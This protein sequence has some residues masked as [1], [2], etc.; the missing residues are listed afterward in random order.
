MHTNSF[1]N[2]NLLEADLVEESTKAALVGGVA[3]VGSQFA[4]NWWLTGLT[5]TV[6]RHAPA[7]AG[8]F[9]SVSAIYMSSS[10]LAAKLRGQN[11][12]VNHGI[13]GAVGGFVIGS[14]SK[15]LQRAVAQSAL[16]GVLS[17]AAAFSYEQSQHHE[18][19]KSFFKWPKPDAFEKVASVQK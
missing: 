10:V 5:S 13:G 7:R 9:A 1:F 6:L 18:E 16:V 12:Y 2:E 11:D 19:P 17:L 4:K 15:S 14:L 8:L 3:G